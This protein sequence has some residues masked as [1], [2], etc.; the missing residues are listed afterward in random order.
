MLFNSYPFV[1]LFLP[2]CLAG[3]FL[4]GRIRTSWAVSWLA[5]GSLVFY[6][7]WDYRYIPLLLI[8]IT[9][10]YFAGIWI[11]RARPVSMRRARLILIC[12]VAADLALLGYYKY[13][14]FFIGTANAVAGVH[15]DFLHVVLP[16]GISFFTFT[17]IAFLADS[18]AGQV[19]D[20]RFPTYL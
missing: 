14:D 5:L 3:Y 10:N 2:L 16:L 11:G 1:L 20:Y 12:A 19:A 4:G 15:I 13:A 18:Y 17:Q 7:W 8:S 6:A 9:F